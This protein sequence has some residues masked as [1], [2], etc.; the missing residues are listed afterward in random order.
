MNLE[1]YDKNKIV[2]IYEQNENLHDELYTFVLENNPVKVHEYAQKYPML[3]NIPC[4]GT[5]GEEGLLHAACRDGFYE[6]AQ[7]LINN[8]ADVEYA[9]SKWGYITPILSAAMHGHSSIISLLHDRSA[10]IDGH[11][12]CPTTPLITSVTDGFSESIKYI[13]SK[14]PDVNRLQSNHN[15]TALDYAVRNK[16][17]DIIKILEEH[18]CKTA[19][20]NLS[21]TIDRAEGIFECLIE[22]GPIFAS[23][24]YTR[25]YCAT[26]VDIR[27]ALIGKGDKNKIVFS[28]GAYE[29]LP[30]M[31]FILVLPN[32][33]P[34]NASLI[35]SNDFYSFPIEL[36]FSI[37]EYRLQ[38]NNI[39]EGFIIE[40]S[41]KPWD[42]LNW[43]DEVDAFVVLNYPFNKQNIDDI[44]IDDLVTLFLLTPIKYPKSGQPKGQKLIEWLGKKRPLAWHRHSLKLPAEED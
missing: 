32:N 22:V 3:I 39:S 19:Y 24:I 28:I 20:D 15:R 42:M 31:E 38:G 13:L 2:Q 18:G 8:G 34:I 17:K 5:I 11:P 30:H 7:I 23:E 14:K 29:R 6:I 4:Y 43:P 9:A 10:D 37:A 35:N 40:K 44:D 21:Q 25:P 36:I 41:V 33:W 27:T 16:N 12:R 26:K 1:I